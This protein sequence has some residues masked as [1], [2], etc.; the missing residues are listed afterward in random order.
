MLLGASTI[1]LE[2]ARLCSASSFFVTPSPWVNVSGET[3]VDPS[4]YQPAPPSPVNLGPCPQFQQDELVEVTLHSLR[5][6]T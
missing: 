2:Q 6:T 5:S 4:G 1:L 3:T